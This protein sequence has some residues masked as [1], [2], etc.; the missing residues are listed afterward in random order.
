[1]QD[2]A[3]AHFF[4]LPPSI[5]VVRTYYTTH[6]DVIEDRWHLTCF[7][8]VFF[9][10][11]NVFFSHQS[12]FYFM[13]VSAD[14]TNHG[15][16]K[17]TPFSPHNQSQRKNSI[18]SSSTQKGA[19][20]IITSTKAV[21][22]V[23]RNTSAT[24]TATATTAPKIRT[25]LNRIR[26][27]N[28]NNNNMNNDHKSIPSLKEFMH[29]QTVLHQY[30]NFLKTL[31]FIDDVTW[32]NQLIQDVSSTFRRNHRETNPV[33]IKMALKEGERQLAQL[34]SIVG[35]HHHQHH[36]NNNNNNNNNNNHNRSSH[37]EN[38]AVMSDSVKNNTTLLDPSQNDPD[39][40][41]NTADKEDPRGRVGVEWPW[42]K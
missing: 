30:R 1:M 6:Q 22:T 29:R 20:I 14:E 32:R 11:Y 12:L 18:M 9:T 37:T 36:K 17:K 8:D 4:M 33:A 2:M 28:A 3:T 19:N 24:A 7:L 5:E 40:W 16:L 27:P 34:Q 26:N 25:R 23:Q 15:I 13:T 31:S 38:N 10:V 21:T 39:S 42:Q 41:I 35:Y